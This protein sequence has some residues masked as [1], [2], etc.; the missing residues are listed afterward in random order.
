MNLLNDSNHEFPMKN[1]ELEKLNIEMS[2]CRK[3]ALRANCQQVVFGSGNPQA[4]IM[5]IGE[6]PG[7]NEDKLGIPFVGSTGKILDKTLSDIKINR[8]D[9]YLTNICKCRPIKNR[10]PLPEELASCSSWLQNQIEIIKP[11]IIVT[12]GRYALNYFLP[13]VK[14]SEVHGKT[15]KINDSKIGKINLYP[16]HHPAAARIN[17]KTKAIFIEDF[18]KLPP[19]LKQ[20]KK[21]H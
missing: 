6:A 18:Q 14:I 7:E 15:L 10:D 16:I 19:I 9:V 17:R 3:C 2:Q 4:E 5:F 20:I 13:D 21:E 8:E 12:L 1:E 11:K